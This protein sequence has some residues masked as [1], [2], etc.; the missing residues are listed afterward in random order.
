MLGAEAFQKPAA[1]QRGLFEM[2]LIEF[3]EKKSKDL[4]HARRPSTP[5]QAILN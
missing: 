5:V 1:S 3:R 2:T 4:L